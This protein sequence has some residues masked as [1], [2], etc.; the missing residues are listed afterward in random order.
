M[1]AISFISKRLKGSRAL[2]AAAVL[3][4]AVSAVMTLLTP[5]IIKIIIDYVLGNKLDEAPGTVI[6][7]FERAGGL[8][9][10][11]ANLWICGIAIVLSTILNSV[12]MYYRGKLSAIAA[13]RIAKNLR[14]DLYSHIQRLPYDELVRIKTGDFIQRCTSDVDTVRRFLSVQLVEGGRTVILIG[15]IVFVMTLQSVPF[16]LVSTPMIPLVFLFS[17]VFFILVR[18]AFQL[19]DEAEGDM[20]TVLQENL[21]GIRVV[22][23]FGRQRYET[24][25]FEEKSVLFRELD[26][27]LGKLVAYFWSASEFMCMAQMSAILIV[28][29]IWA[30]DGKVTLGTVL[31]FL[32]YATQ[33][34]WP[35]RQL[36]QILADMGRMSISISRLREILEMPVENM[37]EDGSKPEITGAVEFKNVCFEYNS[38]EPV[39]KDISFTAQKGQTIAIMGPT[40]SGKTTLI[41]LLSALYDYT[42][43]S[44][45][46][47]GRELKEMNKEWVRKHVGVVEQEVFLYSK[48]VR[49]NILIANRRASEEALF[50]A[51]KT[52]EMHRVIEEFEEGYDTVVGER[53]MTLSGG[54]KQ[55]VA[56]AR[57][58]I[59]NYPILVFDDSLSAVDT[60]TDA[61]IRKALKRRRRD[62]TTFIIAHRITTL[63]DADLILVLEDGRITQAGTHEELITK[64]GLYKR[65]WDLQGELESQVEAETM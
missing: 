33:L 63:F 50:E 62:V 3:M 53:G 22:R 31:L 47:D 34:M 2:Y 52:A 5:Y 38:G 6:W 60:E 29:A 27:K 8:S 21:T 44:L 58:I 48:P 11:R 43:G 49:D 51:A 25:K 10:I 17:L 35:I 37:R 64:D 24:D 41:N 15:G 7:V 59:G 65:I 39:L 23:A 61:A 1:K 28:G 32:N 54:Q 45:T 57:T 9:F 40:G 19:T 20:M 56:I 30:V 26:L 42:S 12:A 4:V 55:R 18:D 16:T 36:G 46:F 13:E 14:D